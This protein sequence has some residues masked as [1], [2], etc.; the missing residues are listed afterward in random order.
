MNCQNH[1][2]APDGSCLE[3]EWTGAAQAR[4]GYGAPLKLRSKEEE[5]EYINKINSDN[6]KMVAEANKA[7]F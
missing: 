6:R 1:D 4:E 7:P 3:I 2:H 5:Q